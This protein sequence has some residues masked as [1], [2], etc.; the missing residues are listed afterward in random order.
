MMPMAR[1][2]TPEG[3]HSGRK[4]C[5]SAAAGFDVRDKLD[6]CEASQSKI[7][8]EQCQGV[9]EDLQAFLDGVED[10]RSGRATARW[11]GGVREL[12][13]KRKKRGTGSDEGLTRQMS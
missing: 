2:K 3:D 12:T 9:E 11:G 8:R 13:E 10:D 7:S 1:T 6:E 5:R 4:R